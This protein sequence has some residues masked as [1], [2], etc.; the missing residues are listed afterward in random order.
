MA[1]K[2]AG[3]LLSFV[4]L[5]KS[6]DRNHEVADFFMSSLSSSES[7]ASDCVLLQLAIRAPGIDVLLVLVLHIG[8]GSSSFGGD[9]CGRSDAAIEKLAQ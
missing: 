6:R 5:L 3:Q 9:D 7:D 1:A 4:C 8:E 2:P